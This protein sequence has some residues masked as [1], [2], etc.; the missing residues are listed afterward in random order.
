MGKTGKRNEASEIFYSSGFGKELVELNG[1]SLISSYEAD[2][3]M[4]HV[5]CR[6]VVEANFSSGVRGKKNIRHEMSK[7]IKHGQ[8]KVFYGFDASII[9]KNIEYRNHIIQKEAEETWNVSTMLGIVFNKNKNQMFEVFQ[10]M[11]EA[12]R[13]GKETLQH[14]SGCCYA[15]GVMDVLLCFDEELGSSNSVVFQFVLLYSLCIVCSMLIC[16]GWASLFPLLYA[17]LSHK[18]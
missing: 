10:R 6:K 9:D 5:S 1:G 12:K 7:I 13:R 4:Y 2:T 8:D 16:D 17:G 18:V 11:E 15:W 3:N 14:N